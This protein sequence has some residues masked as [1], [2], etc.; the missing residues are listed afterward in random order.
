LENVSAL[1]DFLIG[2]MLPE[3]TPWHVA[4]LVPVMALLVAETLASSTAI[5]DVAL[6]IL[7]RVIAH[8]IANATNPASISFGMLIL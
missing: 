5:R 3:S 1:S 4:Q 8:Q 2:S 6:C 7:L